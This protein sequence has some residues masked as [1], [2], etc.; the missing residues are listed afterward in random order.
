MGSSAKKKREKKKDFQVPETFQ[1][2]FDSKTKSNTESEAESWKDETESC[3]SHRDE[4][5]VQ[6]YAIANIPCQGMLIAFCSHR[7]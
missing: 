7:T 5:Q 3:K 1:H 4:L 2:P 6:G